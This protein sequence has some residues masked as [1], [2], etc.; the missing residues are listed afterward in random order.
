MIGASRQETS[1]LQ[2]ASRGVNIGFEVLNC[3]EISGRG[4]PVYISID[5]DVFDPS[6]APGVGFS[7]PGGIFL[8]EF[9]IKNSARVTFGS[10]EE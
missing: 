9:K 8:A 3:S 1:L 4:C 5:T 6:I 2:G 10:K 7:L